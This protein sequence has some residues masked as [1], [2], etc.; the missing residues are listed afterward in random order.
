MSTYNC[1]YRG[2]DIFDGV[3]YKMSFGNCIS[4]CFQNTRCLYFNWSNQYCYM[5]NENAKG[6]Y[7]KWSNTSQTICGYIPKRGKRSSTPYSIT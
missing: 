5:K 4:K 7:W 6:T 3:Q 2:G 1:E